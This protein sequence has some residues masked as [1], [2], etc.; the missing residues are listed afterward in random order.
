MISFC[1]SDL[2]SL[3][4][5]IFSHF[6]WQFYECDFNNNYLPAIEMSD[7]DWFWQE[8][9]VSDLHF[10]R[11]CDRALDQLLM[12]IIHLTICCM[13][14]ILGLLNCFA[15]NILNF[16][17]CH[18]SAIFLS[19][20]RIHQHVFWSELLEDLKLTVYFISSW[21]FVDDVFSGGTFTCSISCV[22]LVGVLMSVWNHKKQ[23]E[24]CKY[25]VVKWFCVWND[26]KK[27]RYECLF[28]D[29]LLEWNE[30]LLGTFCI[31]CILWTFAI[32]CWHFSI[33]KAAVVH[34][35]NRKQCEIVCV[36]A[37]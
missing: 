16:I 2:I 12:R 21:L 11:N 15:A 26:Q 20:Q 10:K 30:F 5:Q 37:L 17:Y 29:W 7:A 3:V 33:S 13:V 23:H 6:S 25:F 36:A 35:N 32:C 1:W 19:T 34:F 28:S 9:S 22:F 4:S 24:L 8:S 31:D 14:W 18:L 27:F